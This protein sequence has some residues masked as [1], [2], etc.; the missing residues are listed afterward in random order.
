MNLNYDPILSD[1]KKAKSTILSLRQE[2]DLLKD[3]CLE[4]EQKNK[5][6]KKKLEIFQQEYNTLKEKL[7]YSKC[8]PLTNS[9]ISKYSEISKE[10]EKSLK[11]KQIHLFFP[12]K[13]IIESLES[14][15]LTLT[16]KILT[17]FLHEFV[18]KNSEIEE[19][20]VKYE[21]FDDKRRARLMS[22]ETF[23]EVDESEYCR[24]INESCS[25]LET[26]DKQ[27]SRIS[28]ISKNIT[29]VVQND[30]G[31]KSSRSLANI[32]ISEY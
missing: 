2:R 16:I 21:V 19:N 28:T 23:G 11:N 18:K 25:L 13:K 3:T 29:K 4:L 9:L 1:L 20:S 30:Q 6:L 8:E 24:L 5:K 14:G 7:N 27:N 26:L 12:D 10:L 22:C 32:K 15:K 17:E 31:H